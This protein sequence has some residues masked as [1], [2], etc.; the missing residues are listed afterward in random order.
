MLVYIA[1][2]LLTLCV[3][4]AFWLWFVVKRVQGIQGEIF[5]LNADLASLQCT[6]AAEK[7]ADDVRFALLERKVLS[8]GRQF[9]D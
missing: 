4:F 7:H 8:S 6:Q 1:I 2:V 9:T 5:A 3:M